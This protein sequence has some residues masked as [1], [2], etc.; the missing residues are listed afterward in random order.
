MLLYMPQVC[1]YP[2]RCKPWSPQ[3]LYVTGVTQ[4][5]TAMCSRYKVAVLFPR[6]LEQPLDGAL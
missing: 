6:S 3:V 5:L 4:L 2:W 1:I